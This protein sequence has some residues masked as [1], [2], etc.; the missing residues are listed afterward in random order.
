MCIYILFFVLLPS[1]RFLS[2]NAAV[3]TGFLIYNYNFFVSVNF[4]LL[5]LMLLGGGPIAN[6]IPTM[7]IDCTVLVVLLRI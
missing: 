2:L 1:P 4:K 5:I 6:V 7:R 3:Q